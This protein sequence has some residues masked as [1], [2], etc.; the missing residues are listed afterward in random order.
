M[1]KTCRGRWEGKEPAMVESPPLHPLAAGSFAR[2]RTDTRLKQTHPFPSHT[3]PLL[4]ASSHHPALL[5]VSS[6][7][8]PCPLARSRSGKPSKPHPPLQPTVLPLRARPCACRQRERATRA[9]DI[10]ASVLAHLRDIC[11]TASPA[12]PPSLCPLGA[13]TWR[14]SSCACRHCRLSAE[15]CCCSRLLRACS[16]EGARR[17]AEGAR[18]SARAGGRAAG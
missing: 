13:A 15:C 17:S 4:C 5:A 6:T 9:D 16:A 2:R 8:P 14:R 18:R 1:R 7:S 11:V 10:S 3:H 12:S